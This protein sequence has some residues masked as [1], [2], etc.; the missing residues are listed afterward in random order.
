MTVN[1]N[2]LLE[3]LEKQYGI[4][5]AARKWYTS[6]LKPR[7]F[8]VG[9]RGARSQPRQLDYSVPLGSVQGA[10]LFIAYA[11]TLD[12]V[13]QPSGLELNSFVDDHSIC[14]TFKSSKLDHKE[15]LDTI[16]NIEETM[17]DIKSWIE[18]VHLK[19][20]EANTEFI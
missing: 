6:Y 17:L 15:E 3:V 9:I 11:S 20:N 18:Q 1:H 10:F 4:V 12:L 7:T 16:A 8:R 19:L 13:V 14:T 2:L 5:G